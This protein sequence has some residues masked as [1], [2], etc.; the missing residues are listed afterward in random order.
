PH[1]AHEPPASIQ[2]PEPCPAL[3]CAAA[4]ADCQ[5]SARR[6]AKE[7]LSDRCLTRLS[8]A[9]AVVSHTERLC[10]KTA[11]N[12]CLPSAASGLNGGLEVVTPCGNRRCP[13]VSKAVG[14]L[15]LST[16]APVARRRSRGPG[17]QRAR[18]RNQCSSS[19][20]WHGRP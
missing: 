12:N 5:T 1:R 4:P 16:Q 3:A 11:G 8:P 9:V 7:H 19:A 2:M 14:T 17:M 6:G 10:R 20:A 15:R 13:E 18:P